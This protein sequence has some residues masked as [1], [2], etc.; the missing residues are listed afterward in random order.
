MRVL[1][2]NSMVVSSKQ[3][4]ASV[5][6]KPGLCCLGTLHL[7]G[8]SFVS[9]DLAGVSTLRNLDICYAVC[10]GLQSPDAVVYYAQCGSLNRSLGLLNVG[11]VHEPLSLVKASGSK[12]YEQLLNWLCL[13]KG[14]LHRSVLH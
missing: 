7:L 6:L 11:R 4:T 5:Q 12:Q 14:S 9:V 8:C 1:S 13:K 2:L 3:S 10:L